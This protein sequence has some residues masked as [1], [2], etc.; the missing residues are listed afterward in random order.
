MRSYEGGCH[1]GAVRFRVTADL[2]A[3]EIC[4]CSICTMKGFLLLVVPQERFELV[5]G[6][7]ALSVY[8]FNTGVAKHEFCRQCGIHPFY[9]PRSDPDKIDV[10]VRCLDGVDPAGLRPR[11]FDGRN[12]EASM[13]V[14]GPA[15][16]PPAAERTCGEELA[17]DAEVPRAW[18][19]LMRHVATNM[20]AHARWV[21]DATPAARAE[22][23]ALAGVAAGYRA[24]A[25][26][27]DGAA[28]AM[29]A[30]RALPAA[31][32]DPAR[33]DRPALAAWMREKIA[34]QRAFAALVLRHADDSEAALSEIEASRPDRGS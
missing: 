14:R 6:D 18:A 24:M 20:D 30:M 1:C 17:S 32:H 31:P 22:C 21:G 10:N 7:G 28:A 13:A 26:A 27:A 2:G 8:R 15:P 9:V 33:L 5:R 34:L 16:V 4:N 12:W 23:D 3:A 25:E 19:A 11:F 29:V